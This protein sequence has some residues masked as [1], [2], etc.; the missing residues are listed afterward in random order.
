MFYGG[1]Y[2]KFC[3]RCGARLNDNEETCRNCGLFQ[4]LRSDAAV[5]TP[6]QFEASNRPFNPQFLRQTASMPYN[7]PTIKIRQRSS[8]AALGFFIW[9]LILFFFINII[10]TPLAVAA[11]FFAAAANAPESYERDKKLFYAKLLCII[12][13]VVDALTLLV[14]IAMAILSAKGYYFI[15]F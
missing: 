15:N 13:T 2:M 7:I 11:A 9:S 6:A 1:R 10:G 12:A 14:M 4:A 3:Q 8:N 5:N